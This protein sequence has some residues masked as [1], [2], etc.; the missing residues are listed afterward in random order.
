MQIK[1]KSFELDPYE[2]CPCGSS[3]KFKFCCYAKARETN[4][5]QN[6]RPYNYSDDRLKNMAHSLWKDTDFKYCFANDDQC[7]GKIKSAHS[8]QNNRVLNRIS[9]EGL[10]SAD[11][12]EFWG[13]TGVLYCKIYCVYMALFT[14]PI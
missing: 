4:R 5:K 6:S 1:D 10:I 9:E 8:I 13:S 11:F 2:D 12:F 3:K 7:R 14:N